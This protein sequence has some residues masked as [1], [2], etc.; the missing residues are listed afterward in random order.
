M[1][2]YRFPQGTGSG[3]G[4]GDTP[5]SWKQAALAATA[6]ANVALV[7]GAPA[8]LDGVPLSVGSRVV[9]KDQT[10][11]QENGIYAVAILGGGANG[12]WT[13][14]P[15]ANTGPLLEGAAIVVEEGAVNA[16]KAFLNTAPPPIVLGTTPI[17]FVQFSGGSEVDSGDIIR[18]SEV[19]TLL[20]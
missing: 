17:T 10:L 14:T 13:R 6:G 16:D 18:I 7:G 11:P 20:G 4:G 9:V 5:L 1:P 19:N 12:T 2:L 15:D 3:G 8:T